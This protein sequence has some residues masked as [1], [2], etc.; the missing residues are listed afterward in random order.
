MRR[1]LVGVV[2]ALAL[3][4]CTN[5]TVPGPPG[6]S[7]A[8]PTSSTGVKG[9]LTYVGGPALSSP[10]S[11]QLEGGSVL[12]YTQ[13]GSERGATEFP[14]GQGFVLPLAPGTYRLVAISGDA[15]C[16]SR[17]VTVESDRYEAVR[18]R[19]DIR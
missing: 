16:P 15:S 18:I 19:C 11:L 10:A 12:A 14:E 8:T 1:M 7:Q 4:A 5:S 17:S 2:A 9:D 3:T 6:G 13:D